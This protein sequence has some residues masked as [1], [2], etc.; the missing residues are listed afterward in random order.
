[1]KKF[2]LIVLIIIV[3]VAAI[4][5]WQNQEQVKFSL[6]FWELSISKTLV[7][8]ITLIIGFIVGILCRYLCF[9]KKD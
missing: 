2:K 6:L 5:F 4:I 3:A 8:F 7:L 9:K 1:M